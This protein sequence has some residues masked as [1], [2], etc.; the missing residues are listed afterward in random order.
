MQKQIFW[1]GNE[2]TENTDVVEAVPIKCG[3]S[4]ADCI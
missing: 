3:N 2:R 1:S 4:S